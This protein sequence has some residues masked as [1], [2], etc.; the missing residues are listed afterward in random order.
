[1]S[2]VNK[3]ISYQFQIKHNYKMDEKS[4]RV[5]SDDVFSE[6]IQASGPKG[7]LLCIDTSQC[8]HKGGLVT[9][10]DVRYLAMFQYLPKNNFN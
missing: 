5:K 10:D 9:S 6:I 8:F 3:H 7:T 1:M 2:I 4:K